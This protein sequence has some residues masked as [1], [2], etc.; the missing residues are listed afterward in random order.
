MVIAA[1][2]VLCFGSCFPYER[3]VLRAGVGD[4]LHC[5]IIRHGF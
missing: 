2:V 1:A 4:H 3:R 5:A